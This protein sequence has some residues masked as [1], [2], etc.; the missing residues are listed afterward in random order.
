MYC[1]IAIES[2]VNINEKEK[3]KKKTSRYCRF[4]CIFLSLS[5]SIMCDFLYLPVYEQ[6]RFYG[7]DFD[8]NKQSRSQCSVVV[9]LARTCKTM[10]KAT[11]ISDTIFAMANFHYA[12]AKQKEEKKKRFKRR[13][14]YISIPIH[15]A[16]VQKR[17]AI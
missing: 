6:S 11:V 8:D 4:S 2:F 13:R 3:N 9:V 15:I 7:R 1:L 17:S 14:R 16:F 5:L 10:L 12:I